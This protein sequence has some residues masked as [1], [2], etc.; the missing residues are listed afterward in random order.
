MPIPDGQRVSRIE[1][2]RKAERVLSLPA[3]IRWCGQAVASD[4]RMPPA[5]FPDPAIKETDGFYPAS[6]SFGHRTDTADRQRI[7]SLALAPLQVNPVRNEIAAA[8]RLTLRITLEPEEAPSSRIL[9]APP[10]PLSPGRYSYLV[11]APSNLLYRAPAPWNFQTLCEAREAA[12]HTTVTVSTEWIDAHYTERRLAER[13]RAFVF[14]QEGVAYAQGVLEEYVA[15]AKEA[16][17]AFPAGEAVELLKG[18][19]DFIGER[20]S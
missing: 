16:L 17:R 3:P 6:G 18:L 5:T 19:A 14:A 1:V 20:Q 12:G 10:S 15:K 8:G 11:V 4:G 2:I 9:Q 7:L 13:I